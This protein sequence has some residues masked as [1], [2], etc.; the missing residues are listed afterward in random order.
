MSPTPVLHGDWLIPG[1][2]L[3]LIGAYRPDMRE[4]DDTALRRA[5]LFV[6]SRTSAAHIGEI[7]DPLARGVITAPTSSAT[8]TTSSPAASAA[9]TQPR[10][11][12]TRTQAARTST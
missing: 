12:S 5:R 4:A 8:C 11:R 3:D 10:S 2:H 9:V 1:Q 7:A 6:D